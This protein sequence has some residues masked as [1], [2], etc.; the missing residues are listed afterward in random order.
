[1]VLSRLLH[2]THKVSFKRFAYE[3]ANLVVES[4]IFE[5]FQVLVVIVIMITLNKVA[6]TTIVPRFI[7]FGRVNLS[8]E[9]LREERVV[10]ET[11]Q[12]SLVKFTYSDFWSAKID[13]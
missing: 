3:R 8:R 7:S 13:R 4:M 1:M 2:P 6:F 12:D 10:P 5:I 11:A 9:D